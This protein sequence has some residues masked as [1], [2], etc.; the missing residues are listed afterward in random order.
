D[1]IQQA[2]GFTDDT[3]AEDTDLTLAI[4]GLGYRVRY[5]E[6]AVGFTEA[7]QGAGSL[8]K[9]R[10]RWQFGT[11]QAAWKH[12]HA[13]GGPQY[14][15]LGLVALPSIWLFQMVVPLLSPLAESMMLIGLVTGNGPIVL[16]YYGGLLLVEGL[17]ALLAY[18]L[19]GTWPGELTL[20][21]VQ[22]IY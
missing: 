19:E 18:A 22:R 9:Q 2:G 5:E 14:G 17:A 4:R 1:L 21:A 16:R 8:V 3:L 12:R 15:S 6:R 7:P 13:C 20:L 10:F 11:L